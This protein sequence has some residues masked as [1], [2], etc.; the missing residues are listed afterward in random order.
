MV[1]NVRVFLSSTYK[2][3]REERFAVE[4]A[5]RLM[6]I[7][8]V[9]MEYFG[10][11]DRTPIEVCLD[12]VRQCSIYVGIIGLQ[13]GSF[14]PGTTMSFTEHEYEEASK[15]RTVPIAVYAPSFSRRCAAASGVR[16]TGDVPD[17]SD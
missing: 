2:D 15:K 17:Q 10:S 4:K 6:E 3:M 9:G 11:D 8:F 13:Y 12:R 5:I 7:P 16:T 1:P 14:V